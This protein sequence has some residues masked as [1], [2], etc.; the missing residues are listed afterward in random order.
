MKS[1]YFRT[2]M[3]IFV[4]SAIF[5]WILLFVN[6]KVTFVVMTSV[7]SYYFDS[8]AIRQGRAQV[9]LGIKWSYVHNMGSLAFSSII[10]GIVT[11]TR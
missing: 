10:N 5:L 3:L 8:N 9:F 1:S 6:T 2:D 11:G 4:S 7:S